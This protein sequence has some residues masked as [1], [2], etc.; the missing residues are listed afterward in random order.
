MVVRQGSLHDRDSGFPQGDRFL[1]PLFRLVGQS[2]QPDRLPSVLVIGE[3]SL[4]LF[5]CPLQKRERCAGVPQFKMAAGHVDTGQK[6][7]GV[8]RATNLL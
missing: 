4:K 2:V 6:D 7:I 1:E 5:D 3:F 8:K